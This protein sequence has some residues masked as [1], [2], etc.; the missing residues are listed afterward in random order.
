MFWESLPMIYFTFKKLDE[1][2]RI[3]RAVINYAV[4]KH[5]RHRKISLKIKLRANGRKV[6]NL[7]V[8]SSAKKLAN[9]SWSSWQRYLIPQQL[10][11]R[12]TSQSGKQFFDSKIRLIMEQSSGG[13]EITRLYN[14]FR[15]SL[16]DEERWCSC[17]KKSFQLL[18]RPWAAMALHVKVSLKRLP[19]ML[20][21][22]GC[23]VLPPFKRLLL[24]IDWFIEPF[25]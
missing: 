5:K 13:E 14:A 17:H 22:S 16:K 1:K 6:A 7:L 3:W 11:T 19:K 4:F 20:K 15:Q 21:W 24:L 9:Q 23:I 25:K 12:E 2:G 18:L 8:Q 10:K